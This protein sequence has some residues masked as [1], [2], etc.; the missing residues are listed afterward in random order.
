MITVVHIVNQ[1]FAAS[2]VKTSRSSRRLSE[3]AVGGAR[4]ATAVG[5]AGEDRH[6]V[7]F[8]DNYFHEHKKKRLRLFAQR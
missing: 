5:S 3:G 8:G 4:T 2:A 7:H 6:T 1:F